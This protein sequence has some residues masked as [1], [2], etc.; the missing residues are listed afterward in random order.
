MGKE[1]LLT[2]K[3]SFNTQWLGLP[4]KESRQIHKKIEFLTQNP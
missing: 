3:P 2:M 1:W 4:L